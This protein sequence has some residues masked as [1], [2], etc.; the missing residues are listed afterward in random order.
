VS[1]NNTLKATAAE[2]TIGGFDSASGMWF[3]A[4]ANAPSTPNPPPFAFGAPGFKPVIGD[5][6]ND[7]VQTV[8]VF[9]PGLSANDPNTA[10]WFLRNENGTGSP[11][12]GMFP[13]GVPGGI[14]I[15]GD[16]TGTGKTGIGIFDPS[17]GTWFLRS[18]ATVGSPD[19]GT[20]KFGMPGWIPVVGDWTG[21]G[22]TG[23]GAF[24]PTTGLFYLRN[25]PSAGQP[26]AGVFAFGAPG[27][28]PFAGDWMG[29]GKTGIGV[30]LPSTVTFFLRSE[31]NAGTPDA[32]QFAFGLPTFLPVAG[33]YTQTAAMAALGE[34]PSPPLLDSATLAA[35]NSPVLQQLADPSPSAPVTPGVLGSTLPNAPGVVVTPDAAAFGWSGGSTSQPDPLMA[36][37]AEQTD[38][39]GTQDIAALDSIFSQ[40]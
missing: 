16:W 17:S 1:V 40:V 19:V 35:G 21:T 6:N 15:S 33:H 20:F 30:F 26:D 9:D 37:L 12:A 18:T 24:D 23:I 27:F 29:T 14:P 39:S 31:A 2:Q 28:L 8:G 22:H 5:W 4:P 3:L 38:Q 10:M 25:E 11:D 32:G 34:L 36:V 13:F 7:G